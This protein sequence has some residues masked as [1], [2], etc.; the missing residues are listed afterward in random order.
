MSTTS[1]ATMPITRAGK[2]RRIRRG[3]ALVLGSL[4]GTIITFIASSPA[5]ALPAFAGGYLYPVDTTAVTAGGHFGAQGPG[6]NPYT[7]YVGSLRHLGVDLPRGA[8]TTV[9]AIADGDIVSVS[10]TNWDRQG[11]R[12]L[13]IKH[14]NSDGTTFVALYGHIQPTVTAGKVTRGQQ[15][16]TIGSYT[17]GSHLHLGIAPNGLPGTSQGAIACSG[18]PREEGTSELACPRGRPGR[19]PSCPSPIRR[20]SATMS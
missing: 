16:G 8:G 2:P 15:I 12:A 4:I 6:C 18:L 20:S 9:H 11:N 14:T 10:S 1:T 17:G 13:G 19:M 5:S 3:A 7:G